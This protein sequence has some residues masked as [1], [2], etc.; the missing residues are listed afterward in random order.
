MHLDNNSTLNQV[1]DKFENINNTT[2]ELNQQL[3]DILINKNVEVKEDEYKLGALIEKV[4][5]L[6]KAE[7]LYLYKEGNEC[8]Y[9]TGGWMQYYP[10]SSSP[11]GVFAKCDTY[12]ECGDGGTG[13]AYSGQRS[14]SPIDVTDYSKLY[15]D[16][17]SRDRNG[18]EVCIRS[19]ICRQNNFDIRGD[20]S[21]VG[22]VESKAEGRQA[23]EIDLTNITG[24]VY[25]HCNPWSGSYS[26]GKCIMQ[27]YNIWLE[28]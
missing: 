10:D 1:I 20:D 13:F 22:F 24:L 2:E 18:S 4:D 9:I 17:S 8:I 19:Y 26:S 28:S 3:S 7:R 25:V 6:K 16:A 5:L 12:I 23:L 15:I 27:T 11:G 14:T 21:T